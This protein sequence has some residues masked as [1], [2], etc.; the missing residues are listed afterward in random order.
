MHKSH[1]HSDG[2]PMTASVTDFPCAI[3]AVF[4]WRMNAQVS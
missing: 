4:C 2:G 1:P 3:S